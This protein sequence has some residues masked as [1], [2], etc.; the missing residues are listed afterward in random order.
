MTFRMPDPLFS[1][2][3][4]VALALVVVTAGTSF[5]NPMQRRLR[6]A[7]VRVGVRMWWYIVGGFLL[8][9]LVGRTAAVVALGLVSFV[10]FKEFLTL[11]PTRRA[12]S[13][14]LLWAY[15]TIPL[16][17]FWTATGWYGMFI[18][19]IPV[20]VFLLLP[21]RMVLLGETRGFLRAVGVIHWGLMTTVFCVSHLAYLIVLPDLPELRNAG[22]SLLFFVVVIT[23]FNDA[24]QFLVNRRFGRTP[25]LAGV[26]PGL[27]REG[28]VAGIASSVL[29]SIALAPLFTPFTMPRAAGVGLMIGLFGFIGFVAITAVQ[30]DLGVA[31]SSDFLPGHGGLLLRLDSLMFTAPLFFHSVYY[32]YY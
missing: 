21:M 20:Y 18:V 27:T 7:E 19:F 28:L 12:D 29:A 23:Q 4:V 32:L 24:V 10:A 31:E 16:Q 13:K 22:I 25:I 17:Y 1:A 15:L 6:D 11:A 8:A 9:L 14:V 5:A 26:R 2:L 3:A 30:R